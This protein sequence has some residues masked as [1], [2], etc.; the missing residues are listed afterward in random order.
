MRPER[1]ISIAR[2]EPFELR[3]F[4]ALPI[5]KTP[6]EW[7]HDLNGFTN[8][9]VLFGMLLT[10][11]PK[12]GREI[13]GIRPKGEVVSHRLGVSHS[14]RDT[15]VGV[16]KRYGGSG[17]GLSLV[18]ELARAMG[19][20][21]SVE[22]ALGRGSR[23]VLR[24]PGIEV[25]ASLDEPTLS[26][27][28][29]SSGPRARLA[30]VEPHE[31][32]RDA[33][34]ATLAA[35][36]CE[37]TAVASVD[38]LREKLGRSVLA[39]VIVGASRALDPEAAA[40]ALEIV[41]PGV[42][43]VLAIGPGN[44][45]AAQHLLARRAFD[46]TTL[47]PLRRARLIAVL[48]DLAT[49]ASTPH[50]VPLVLVV[51]DDPVNRRL[52]STLVGRAGARVEMVADGPAA[53]SRL[54]RGDVHLA[55]LDLNLPGMDGAA[56]AEAV[57]RALP[58]A[59]RPRMIA[60]TAS[61][62]PAD[63]ERCLAAGMD[64]YLVRPVAVG[65]ITDL[66]EESARRLRRQNARSSGS[67]LR[68]ETVSMEATV[69]TELTTRDATLDELA[70]LFGATEARDVVGEYRASATELVAELERALSSGERATA[71]RVAH[72]LKSSSGSMGALEVS[73]LA[74]AM[75]SV[76]RDAPSVEASGARPQLAALK[77]AVE[78]ADAWLAAWLAKP[79]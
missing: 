51:D 22:S 50:A 27:P 49:R 73:R 35:I 39:G 24:L 36:G 79:A 78:R 15:G 28:A 25:E 47:R 75:E 10:K 43:R 7:S 4:D 61:S 13:C 65:T 33:A 71:H 54:S 58:P 1:S 23:F 63:R 56:V 72:T 21:V 41:L 5:H 2:V 29:G 53:L 16:Y 18:D 45:P 31:A 11:V 37:V 57:T 42:P 20:S 19:G 14:C 74:A 60:L 34:V 76:L 48:D 67:A 70:A 12:E 3:G 32:T 68:P 17:L 38:E 52:T 55:L 6:E 40:R 26:M 62:L 77:S 8:G 30:L 64:G 66:V 69:V 59:V 9:F 46:T 44:T